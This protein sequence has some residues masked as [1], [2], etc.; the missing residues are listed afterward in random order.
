LN[1]T[2]LQTNKLPS[3]KSSF[4]FDDEDEDSAAEQM[5]LSMLKK[6]LNTAE[7][8]DTLMKFASTGDI[9]VLLVELYENE[10][11]NVYFLKSND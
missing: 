5:M 1:V 3:S 9:P 6:C 7:A 4:D 8:N 11:L 2:F 10:G